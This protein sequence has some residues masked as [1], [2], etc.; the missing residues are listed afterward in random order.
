MML[1]MVPTRW[2]S[3]NVSVMDESRPV[4]DIDVSWWREKGVLTIQG[5]R[6]GVYRE[7]LMSGAFVIEHAGTVLARAE[8]PSIFRR[9][10]LVHHEGRDYTLRAMS[11]F[12]RRFLLWD[13]SRQIGSLA[14]TSVFRRGAAVDLPDEWPL[15]VQMFIIWLTVILRMRDEAAVVAGGGL[16]GV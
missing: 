2:Y 4:A 9:T 14:P 6:Y 12:G 13:G 3:S 16:G 1:Q 11:A 10:F 8:K 7:G 15:P 5:S